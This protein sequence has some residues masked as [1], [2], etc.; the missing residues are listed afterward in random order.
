M[1]SLNSNTSMQASGRT[2]ARPARWGAG[3]GFGRSDD[4]AL[5]ELTGVEQEVQAG[6]VLGLEPA[7]QRPDSLGGVNAQ[8]VEVEPEIDQR[9]A[10]HERACFPTITV[11][12]GPGRVMIAQSMASPSP[13]M[14]S[15]SWTA[16]ERIRNPAELRDTRV[17]FSG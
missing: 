5:H 16:H 2:R 14:N 13:S 6:G 8:S 11:L 12:G 9:L 3:V 17:L 4:G 10:G 7:A 15:C 1:T